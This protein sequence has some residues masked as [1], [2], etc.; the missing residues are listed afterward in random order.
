[1]SE[2]HE[3]EDRGTIEIS[4]EDVARAQKIARLRGEIIKKL[5]LRLFTMVVTG[6]ISDGKYAIDGN[7]VRALWSI[8]KYNKYGWVTPDGKITIEGYQAVLHTL[9]HERAITQI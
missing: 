8:H 3:I 9:T 7:D 5:D 6:L 2:K 1:M 4:D